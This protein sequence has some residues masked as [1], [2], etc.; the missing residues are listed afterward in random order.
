MS[1]KFKVWRTVVGDEAVTVEVE[2]HDAWNAARQFAEREWSEDQDNT[3]MELEIEDS[4][5]KRYESE[6]EIEMVPDFDV[7]LRAKRTGPP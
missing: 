5:G 1:Q 7:S 3:S 4:F 2:A 6:V